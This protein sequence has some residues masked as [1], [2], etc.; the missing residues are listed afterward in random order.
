MLSKKLKSHLKN[1]LANVFYWV[2]G[3]YLV[4]LL[5]FRKSR[6]IILNYHNFNAH[7]SPKGGG[8]FDCIDNDVFSQ[9]LSFLNHHFGIV[10]VEQFFEVSSSKDGLQVAITFDDGYLDNYTHALPA[11]VANNIKACYFF[12][13]TDYISSNNLLWHDAARISYIH[14]KSDKV[15]VEGKLLAISR[16]EWFERSYFDE[17]AS[18]IRDIEVSSMMMS[19]E[20]VSDLKKHGFEVGAHTCNHT[21]LSFLSAEQKHEQLSCSIK[22]VNS[23]LGQTSTHFAYPNGSFDDFTMEVLAKN[24]IK[25]AYTIKSGCNE[26]TTPKLQLKRIGINTYETKQVVLLKLLMA[27]LRNR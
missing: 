22:L 6:L 18:N 3:V 8:Y 14:G 17:L 5:T 12:V 20:Q 23:K 25:F 16:G 19:W 26:K 4:K 13:T 27:V 7:Y 21:P 15:E 11:L 2:G 1:L 9:Q 24:D 10:S